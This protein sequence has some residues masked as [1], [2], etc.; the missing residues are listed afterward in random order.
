MVLIISVMRYEPNSPEIKFETI[1]ETTFNEE[2]PPIFT[3]PK[4]VVYKK[5]GEY[6][7]YF[8]VSSQ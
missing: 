6:I 4:N 7:Y 3:D 5:V 8:K 1:H 2:P